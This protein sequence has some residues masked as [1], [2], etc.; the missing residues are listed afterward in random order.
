MVGLPTHY[1]VDGV[2]PEPAMLFAIN[3]NATR[4]GLV[5]GVADLKD[6]PKLAERLLAV[7]PALFGVLI[8]LKVV[9]INFLLVSS[10]FVDFNS[11]CIRN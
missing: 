2:P 9:L 7:K 4:A 8:V 5:L 10:L 6:S 3:F 11:E 1:A